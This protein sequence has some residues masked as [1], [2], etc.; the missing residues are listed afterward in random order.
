MFRWSALAFAPLLAI[1]ACSKPHAAS[2]SEPGQ[3]TPSVTEILA[4]APATDWRPVDPENTL[5]LDLPKGRVVIE[6]APSFA[7]NHVAN[8]KALA[9]AHYFDDAYV[10]RVQDNYVVQWSQPDA[11][12][13]MGQGKPSLKAEFDRPAAGVVF[14]PLPDRDTYAPQ[15]GFSD[16]FPAAR[17]PAAGRAWLTHCYGMVGAGRDNDADSGG[18]IELYAVIGNAPRPL[19]RNVTLV[20]RVLQGVELMSAMPRGTGDLGFYEH[21]QER[22][23]IK[24][25]TVAADLPAAQ[26][27]DL[28][29]LK[30]TAGPSPGSSTPSATATTPGTSMRPATWTSAPSRSPSGCGAADSHQALLIARA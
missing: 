20:G 30:T 4:A 11:K 9:R 7:P 3:P 14:E 23:P 16:G 27:L 15:T 6:L 5:Y 25:I 2:T 17:D 12:R 19:D 28:E 22:I 13:P 10:V 26:R 8:I 24:A 29:S 21:P 1:A 18:G